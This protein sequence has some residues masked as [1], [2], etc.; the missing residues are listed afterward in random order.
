MTYIYYNVF[1]VAKRYIYTYIFEHSHAIFKQRIACE[2]RVESKWAFTVIKS[3]KYLPN[4][5]VY[6][7]SDSDLLDTYKPCILEKQS[8]S[9]K[10]SRIG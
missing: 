9:A 4:L 1:I 5:I 7:P 6:L 8:L 10:E 3:T 2:L